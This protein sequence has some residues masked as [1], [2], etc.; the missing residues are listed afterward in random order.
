MGQALP[1]GASKLQ[2]E[3]QKEKETLPSLCSWGEGHG[4]TDKVNWSRQHQRSLEVKIKLPVQLTQ[5]FSHQT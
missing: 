4:Q 1:Q 2:Q 3:L 5:G